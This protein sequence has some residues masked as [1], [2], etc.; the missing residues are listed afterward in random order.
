M[1]RSELLSCRASFVYLRLMHGLESAE[2]GRIGDAPFG[3]RTQVLA[4]RG[5]DDWPDYTNGAFV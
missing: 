1:A 2:G 4:V 5:Q 3:I